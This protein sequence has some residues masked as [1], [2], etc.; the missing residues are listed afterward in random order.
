M[1]KYKCFLSTEVHTD[2]KE[3][4]KRSLFLRILFFFNKRTYLK[5]YKK[6]RKQDI[7]THKA[8]FIQSLHKHA[9]VGFEPKVGLIREWITK[10]LM[11]YD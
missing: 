9:L 6:S 7:R 4:E 5:P 8:V 11:V 10:I 1:Q 2:K 3:K